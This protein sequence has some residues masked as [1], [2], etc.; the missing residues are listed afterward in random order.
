[1]NPEFVTYQK[2]IMSYLDGSLSKDDHAEFEAFV[3]T[4]PE[5]EELI[6]SK[7]DEVN[8]LKSLIPTAV[9]SPM[10]LQGLQSELKTSVYNLLREDSTSTWEKLKLAW[11][12]W[13][14]R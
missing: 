10:M 12:D 6:R 1:M 8:L 9:V 13:I 14:S 4:H 2:K 5:F 11:E 3:M 7:E